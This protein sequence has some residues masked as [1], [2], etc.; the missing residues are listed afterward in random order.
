VRLDARLD[1]LCDI[2]VD[3]LARIADRY[4]V[5][6]RYTDP[7]ALL[8]TRGGH[9]RDGGCPAQHAALAAEVLARGLPM[10]NRTDRR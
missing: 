3:R 9:D 10:F 6:A 8:G 5:G 2:D 7:T 4:G 1:A